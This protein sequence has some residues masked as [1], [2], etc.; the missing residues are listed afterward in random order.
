MVTGAKDANKIFFV[1]RI[2]YSRF[3][4][5][6]HYRIKT[7]HHLALSGYHISFGIAAILSGDSAAVGNLHNAARKKMVEQPIERDP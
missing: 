1:M 2:R 7:V 6:T 5:A 3:E 4:V